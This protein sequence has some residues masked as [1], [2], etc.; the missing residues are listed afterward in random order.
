MNLFSAIEPIHSKGYKMY[1]D[2]LEFSFV[3]F[4]DV[5]NVVRFAPE[6]SNKIEL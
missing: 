2:S 4:G 3:L 6:N 1:M 5:N